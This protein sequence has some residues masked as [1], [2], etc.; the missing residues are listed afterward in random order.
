M[1]K[2]TNPKGGQAKDSEADTDIDADG[3][4][5]D[6]EADTDIDG[7][8]QAKDSE[9]D[10]QAKDNE[11]DTDIDADGQAKD[12]EADGPTIITN[13]KRKPGITL[14]PTDTTI[15][16]CTVELVKDQ[17]V[18]KAGT[19]IGA[20]D[21][22]VDEVSPAALFGA[23]RSFQAGTVVDDKARKAGKPQPGDDQSKE[24]VAE[25]VARKAVIGG[26]RDGA[27]KVDDVIAKIKTAKGVTVNYL[28]DAVVT[29]FARLKS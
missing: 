17:A 24:T 12:N 4:A 7:D 6:N 9:A 10:G 26:T 18:G 2:Q 19:V 20:I 23:L 25:I 3:Q 1:P 8:D 13:K 29:G 22:L 14:D 15:G 28:V 5:K 11:A 27:V 21:S 16:A